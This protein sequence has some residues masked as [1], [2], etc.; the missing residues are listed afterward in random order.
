ME[1][2]KRIIYCIKV[3]VKSEEIDNPI[4]HV[5]YYYLTQVVPFNTH[6]SLDESIYNK[7]QYPSNAMRYLDIVSTDEI[8]PEDTDYEEYL[9][10]SKKDD[11]QLFYVKD[12]V[13]YPL[14]EVHH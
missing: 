11:I 8:F 5:S 10:L 2:L 12:M 4:Y 6:V 13:M 14:D 7:I 3:A 9:Y 1:P